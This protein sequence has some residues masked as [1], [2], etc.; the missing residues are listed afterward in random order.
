MNAVPHRCIV[1]NV[2]SAHFPAIYVRVFEYRIDRDDVLSL[3][4]HD[5]KEEPGVHL[6]T[7]SPRYLPQYYRRPALRFVA[8]V[9]A[10]VTV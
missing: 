3:S 7:P 2:W 1:W 6:A 4:D 5:G 8:E 10:F 9:C